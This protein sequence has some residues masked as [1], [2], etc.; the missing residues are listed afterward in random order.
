MWLVLM[1]NNNMLEDKSFNKHTYYIY[2]NTEEISLKSFNKNFAKI[3][4]EKMDIESAFCE[5]STANSIIQKNK[6]WK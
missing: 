3:L 2:F 1:Q 5:I 4:G 6:S